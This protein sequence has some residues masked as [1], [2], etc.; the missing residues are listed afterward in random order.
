MQVIKV[1]T[2]MKLAAT[3]AAAS[4]HIIFR[5]VHHYTKLLYYT[6]LSISTNF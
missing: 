3:T 4:L 6:Y 2:Y 5:R 1:A